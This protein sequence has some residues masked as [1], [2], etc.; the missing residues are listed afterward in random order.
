MLSVVASSLIGVAF[1]EHNLRVV[2]SLVG[3]DIEFGDGAFNRPQIAARIF[4]DRR[5][6]RSTRGSCK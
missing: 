1:F 3:M 4:D 6:C 5:A 2:Q